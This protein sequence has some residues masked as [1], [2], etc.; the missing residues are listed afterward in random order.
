MYITYNYLNTCN[1]KELEGIGSQYQK[2]ITL[3]AVARK[4]NLKYIETSAK[5]NENIESVF[6]YVSTNLH[7][8]VTDPQT[9]NSD[10]NKVMFE[11]GGY[12][13]LQS[14]SNPIQSKVSCC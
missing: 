3:Y 5:T 9:T 8:Q 13:N 1:I 12:K 4:H 6:V 14:P 2:I 11:I 10:N 7:K